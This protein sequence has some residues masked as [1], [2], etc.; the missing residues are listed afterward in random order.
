MSLT[1]VCCKVLE[2]VICKHIRNHL[3]KY[4]I[5]TNLQHGFRSKHSCESQ[6]LITADDILKQF[7][8]KRSQIDVIILDFSKAFDKVSHKL[9]ISKLNQ[10]GITGNIQQWI[11]AFLS[12]RTQKVVV[13]GEFSTSAPVTSGVP[14]GTVLGPLLFLCYINDLPNCVCSQVRL[15]ADDCLLYRSV[16]TVSDAAILQ[17]DLTALEHWASKWKMHFNPIKCYVMRYSRVKTPIGT[18]Y[19]L[20]N[21]VLEVHT[22]NPYLG[23]LLSDDGKWGPHI[24]AICNKANSTL[25]FLR[26]NLYNCPQQ[27]KDT[28]YKALVRSKLEYASSVWS[29]HLAK[30]IKLLERIQH[31]AARF[32]CRNYDWNNSVTDMLKNLKWDTLEQRRIDNSLFMLFKIVNKDIS[33]DINEHL[34]RSYTKGRKMNNIQFRHIGARYRRI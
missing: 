4:N 16:K 29:P 12:N 34:A 14:Q 28:A 6:L 31:R 5:I 17:T 8:R 10:M 23:V 30:D 9:L 3:D 20:C 19:T 24:N 15:F 21:H 27:L 13:N 22:T 2:H 32:V 25:G 7:D 33:I 1:S 26:R 18:P 11:H